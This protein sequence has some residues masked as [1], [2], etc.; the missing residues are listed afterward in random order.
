MTARNPSPSLLVE[1]NPSPGKL[2]RPQPPEDELIQSRARR[3]GFAIAEHVK[4]F[5]NLDS[6]GDPGGVFGFKPHSPA[7]VEAALRRCIASGI[8]DAVKL[9]YENRSSPPSSS[10]SPQESY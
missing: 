5:Y 10:N 6:D 1:R 9:A 3:L 2:S 4:E 8:L 7:A